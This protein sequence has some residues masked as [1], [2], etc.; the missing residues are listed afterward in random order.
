LLFFYNEWAEHLPSLV[1]K[2]W[3]LYHL[4]LKERHWALIHLVMDSFRYFAA[5]TSFTQLW[6]FVPRDAALSYNASTGTSIEENG[7][8]LELKAYLQRGYLTH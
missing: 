2:K 4:L 6:K 8:V 1:K 7:F 5:R 3:D